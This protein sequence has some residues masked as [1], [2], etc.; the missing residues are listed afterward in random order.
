MVFKLAKGKCQAW[1]NV[2][3]DSVIEKLNRDY[4]KPWFAQKKDDSVVKGLGDLT[5]GGAVLCLVH[6]MY[7]KHQSCRINTILLAIGSTT[8]RNTLLV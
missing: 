2:N 1:L 5:Y 3:A 4:A 7:V 6:L 8:W